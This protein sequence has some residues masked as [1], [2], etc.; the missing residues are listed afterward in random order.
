MVENASVEEDDDLQDCWVAMLANAAVGDRGGSGVEAVF[1]IILKE[2]GIQEVLFLDELYKAWLSQRIEL[3][4]KFTARTIFGFPRF[5][6]TTLKITYAAAMARSKLGLPLESNE[7]E[8]FGLSFDII[9]RNRLLDELFG[10][11]ENRDEQRREVGS[12]YRLSGLGV[13]FIR[14]C[15]TPK[16]GEL[17]LDGS[18]NA[19]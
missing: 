9:L 2:L 14:A 7:Q 16:A 10:L 12:I 13:R 1:P 6:D 8:Q 18:K 5:S 4:T 19:V 3:L 11:V 15:R 17:E